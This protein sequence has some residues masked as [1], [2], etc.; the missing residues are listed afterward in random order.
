V[1]AA[2]SIRLALLQILRE[3]EHRNLA[4]VLAQPELAQSR[5]ALAEPHP[6][7]PLAYYSECDWKVPA[8]C[9]LY[10]PS[11]LEAETVVPRGVTL[12][13]EFLCHSYL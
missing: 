3:E 12:S 13:A 9:S 11:V 10:R 2:C 4:L 7:S 1:E 5:L 8:F 6:L